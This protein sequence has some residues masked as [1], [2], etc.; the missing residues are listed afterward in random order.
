[1]QID[2]TDEKKTQISAIFNVTDTGINEFDSQIRINDASGK[3]TYRNLGRRNTSSASSLR[4]A[5]RG[6][7]ITVLSQASSD[8]EER[9]VSEFEANDTAVSDV[10]F[11]VHTGGP[12]GNSQ[13]TLKTLNIKASFYEPASTEP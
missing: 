8:A 4:I 12:V 6:T 13:V 2:F 10:K 9:F 3:P 11:H 1:M 5:R 7:T